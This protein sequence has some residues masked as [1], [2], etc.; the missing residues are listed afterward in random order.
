M[1]TSSRLRDIFRG[2]S[3]GDPAVGKLRVEY[4]SVDSLIPFANNAR[5]HSDEQIA[6]LAALIREF[7]WTNP[8]LVDGDNGILAGHGRLAAARKLRMLEVPVI[9]L[10]D[11]TDDQKRAY[12][13]ADNQSALNAGWDTEMLSLELLGLQENGFQ[14]DLLGFDAA[15]L[16]DLLAE[17]TAGNTDPDE[18]PPLPERAASRP[19]DLWVL[20]RHRLLCGDCT[21]PQDVSRLLGSVKPGLMVTDPPYGVEYDP[22]W[23]LKAGV[24]KPWQTRAEGKVDNDH[25]CDWRAAWAL[26][27]GDVAYVWHGA[28]HAGQVAASLEAVGFKIRS[29]IIWA[30]NSLVIGRGDY[31]WQHEPCY[32]AVRTNRTGHWSGDRKQSTLWQIANMHATQGSV[33]DGK[34]V[35]SAQKPVEC[36]RRPME[37]NS[38]PGQA[39][40]DPFVGSGTS[41]IAA[42]QTARCCYALEL[43]PQYVDV[44]VRRWQDF[45]GEKATLHGDGR[46]FDEFSAARAS[47]ELQQQA[48]AAATSAAIAALPAEV[49]HAA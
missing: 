42:E 18:A 40:Y 19:G 14:L 7:G 43:N 38:S 28:L 6:Q 32:Y 13:I 3:D 41:L 37:N 22:Q 49:P 24:N 31:H 48:Q 36:M 44:C 20:G 23:R 34:T 35:H 26:F 25:Q 39:V 45:T 11:L 8:I 15:R 47:D 21:A 29:Q 9:E 10:R 33:D 1:K 5:T 16:E 4:R 46:T 27:A 2:G 12:V 17:R 30:K